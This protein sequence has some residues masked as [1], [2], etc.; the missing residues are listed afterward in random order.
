MSDVVLSPQTIALVGGLMSALVVAI[1]ALSGTIAL[2]YRQVL[3][4]R[5]RLLDERNRVL[6][7]RDARL[8]DLWRDMEEKEI[9]IT[10]LEAANERLQKL[11]VDA[12]EGWRQQAT[13]EGRVR[14]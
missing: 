5:D 3:K 2:L 8:V 12:T 14:P 4:E 7:E 9:R 11:A 10:T 1:G 13:G 6:E